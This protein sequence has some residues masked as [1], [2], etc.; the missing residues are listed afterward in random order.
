MTRNCI[1]AALAG[2]LF[3]ACAAAAEPALRIGS[4][5]FTESYI[6]GEILAQAAA[7]RARDAE[8]QP[9]LG[10]TA[11][12]LRGA[13]LGRHRR[14][15]GIHRHHRRARSCKSDAPL[16]LAAINARLAPLGLAASVPLGFSNSY[17]I[18]M[19]EAD[20]RAAGHRGGSPT[21]RGAPQLVLGLS[22]EFLGRR[23]AGRAEGRLRAGRTPPRGLDHGLAYEAL[24]AGRGRRDRPLHHRREDRALRR[25]RP[26]GRPGVLPALRRGRAAPRRCA[27]APS[28]RVRGD[29][30]ACRAASTSRR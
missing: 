23:T 3:A 21:S 9:G 30:A 11:I 1:A 29:R 2:L 28:A 27:A 25:S 15:S 16:D 22:H 6:L 5:R 18:G 12:L 8:H 4:K 26:R 19:R 14:L 13:A 24:A 17:A 7:A 20:A 10:N